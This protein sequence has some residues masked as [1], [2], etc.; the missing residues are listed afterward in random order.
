[1]VSHIHPRNLIL[2]TEIRP[3]NFKIDIRPSNDHSG[4]WNG[5]TKSIDDITSNLLLGLYTINSKL[6][7][8]ISLPWNNFVSLLQLET[9]DYKIILCKAVTL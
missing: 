3:S 7:R 8:G 1:M 6:W 5:L 4:P 2:D 9:I